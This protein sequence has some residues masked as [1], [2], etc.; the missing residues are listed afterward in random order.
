VFINALNNC[1]SAFSVCQDRVDPKKTVVNKREFWA[2]VV[3]YLPSKCEAL[4]SNTS[5]FKNKKE[6][7]ESGVWWHTLVIPATPKAEARGL[8][9]LV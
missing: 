1:L 5:A 9:A 4:N 3:E 7:W 6:F 2:Q 8:K